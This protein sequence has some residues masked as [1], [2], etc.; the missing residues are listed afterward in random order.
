MTGRTTR[1][2]TTAELREAVAQT[3][4]WQEASRGGVAV[5]AALEVARSAPSAI[6]DRLAG[7][8]RI[9]VTGAG[10]SYYIAQVAAATMRARCALP[11]EAVPL[12]EIL[13]RPEGVIGAEPAERQPVVVI[14]R[15]G[16]T[17]EAID[18]IGLAAGRGQPSI[19]VTC[20]PASPM[21]Q[22][23]DLTLAVP[24]ADERAIVMTR[25]FVAQAALLMRLGARVARERSGVPSDDRF[26]AD[27]DAVPGRWG[28]VE[29]HIERALELALTDPSRVV[30][31]GGGAAYGIANEA[32]LKLTETSQVAASAFHPLEF[33]HG[34]I[35]VCEPGMLVVG[36]LGGNA[37]A[38]ERRVV[39][40]S[41]ALGAT[42]WVL[43]PSGPGAELD[44]IARLPLVLHA[45]QGLALGVALR[46]GRDPEAPRHLSQVVVIEEA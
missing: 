27:L 11:A 10:S 33:R 37:E 46:R 23:A 15:S 31:L 20:R 44:E 1:T 12:S 16:T 32:V 40:E 13:L 42:T 36:I 6:I 29:P 2:D 4:A 30:V 8:K 34:P 35:S 39:A 17:T 41:A 5:A 19:A 43:G 28:E 45:L 26:A 38:A 18:V 25:S 9:V 21:A 7:A 24:Q 22:A 3:T 14:S